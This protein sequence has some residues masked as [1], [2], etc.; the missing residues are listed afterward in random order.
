MAD[1][2][3]ADDNQWVVGA[4]RKLNGSA[5]DAELVAAVGKGLDELFSGVLA[6]RAAQD[7]QSRGLAASPVDR[8]ADVFADPQLWSRGALVKMNHPDL[9]E[10]VNPAPFHRLS[11]METKIK[12]PSRRLGQDTSEICAEW[13]SSLR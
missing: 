9:G 12:W 3:P 4:V 8:F 13:G 2:N 6:I 7:L 1:G 5:V 10:T 11:A